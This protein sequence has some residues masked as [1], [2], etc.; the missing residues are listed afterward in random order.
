MKKGLLG[1]SSVAALG[2][3]PFLGNYGH[4]LVA[5]VLVYTLVALSL[6]ILI[7]FAGQIS[8][9]HAAFFALGAYTTAILTTKLGVPFLV[10]V[11]AGGIVAAL[12]GV[13]V[14]LPALRVQ[15][16]YLAIATLGF[17]LFVQQ[18]LYEWESVRLAGATG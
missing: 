2:L 7:G 16:H 13:V 17:A 9:G 3:L 8:I 12:L 6:T 14:A 4:L 15:G 5:T 1:V 10:G 11:L 18:V